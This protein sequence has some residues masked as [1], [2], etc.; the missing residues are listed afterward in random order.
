MT[1][2]NRDPVGRGRGQRR[3]R[4]AASRTC[5]SAACGSPATA[6][7][8][9]GTEALD[10]YSDWKTVYINSRSASGRDAPRTVPSR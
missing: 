10:V 4:T 8:R 1:F 5:R 9:P 6:G 2:L 7:A 3:R